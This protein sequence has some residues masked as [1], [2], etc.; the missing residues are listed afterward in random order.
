[1][2][3]ESSYE[4][5]N[6]LGGAGGGD[7]LFRFY[8]GGV[9][10]NTDGSDEVSV[11]PSRRSSRAQ[12][13]VN[14]GGACVHCKSLKVRCELLAGQSRC[15]R[16]K[17]GNYEC[18]PRTRKKRKPAPTHEDLQLRANGQDLQIERLLRELDDLKAANKIRDRLSKTP[19]FPDAAVKRRY[20]ASTYD[21]M[22]RGNSPSERD[23]FAQLPPLRIDTSLP[24]PRPPDIVRFCSLTSQD[25]GSLF[26][27]FFERVNPYFSI[28]DPDY[29]TAHSLIWTSP[30]LFTVVCATASKYYTDRPEV[31]PVA[32]GFARDA[33]AQSIVEGYKSVDICQAYLLMA[34]YAQPKKKWEEDR[35]W[36]FLGV[37]VRMA[38][39][40]GLDKTR[41]GHD[42][43]STNRIRTWLNCF[44]ADGSHAIQFGKMPMLRL[45]DPLALNSQNWYQLSEYNILFDVHLCAY[46]QVI[47][48]MERWRKVTDGNLRQR[49]RDGFDIVTAATDT[50]EQLAHE[51]VLWL[52]RYEEQNLRQPW[53]ICVYR[54]NTT[55][56]IVAYLRLV[57]LALAFQCVCRPKVGSPRLADIAARAIAAAQ[58]VIHIVLNDLC[59]TGNLKYAMEANF[60]YVSYAA[61]FLVNLLRPKFS[62]LIDVHLRVD[63]F[64]LVHKLVQTLLSPVV[65][66]S[67]SHTPALYARF[68]K[69]LMVK[70]EVVSPETMQHRSSP[71]DENYINPAGPYWPDVRQ[72]E[73]PPSSGSNHSHND[74]DMDLSLTHFV[75]TVQAVPAAAMD[76]NDEVPAGASGYSMQQWQEHWQQTNQESYSQ[77]NAQAHYHEQ[78]YP[79]RP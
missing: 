77:W 20:P 54:G 51:L 7:G 56:L 38:L 75:R 45:D 67:D 13:K 6:Y 9:D 63:L 33:A 1:M 18:V 43:E 62:H 64:N 40:L 15:E 30:F 36:V 29:H 58:E 22:V 39:E 76:L 47:V 8:N 24:N 59:P 60:V 35:R 72:S 31:H 21:V 26:T 73:S 49:V 3:T 44:C 5:E 70:N 32:L 79:W 19:V 78:Q 28:L 25:I 10:D 23:V 53:G 27:L 65:A 71:L 61:G 50:E 12:P 11:A 57:V 55:R 48:I 14:S 52:Q 34:V 37:A 2:K 42:Q 16:C 46:V 69:N 4:T 66:M 68:I 17:L 74:I 41:P